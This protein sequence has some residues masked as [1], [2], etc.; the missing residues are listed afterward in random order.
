MRRVIAC[1]SAVAL[2]LGTVGGAAANAPIKEADHVRDAACSGVSTTAGS[3]EFYGM[4]SDQYGPDGYF[5]VWAGEPYASE[6]LMTRDYDRDISV[7]FD[8][9]TVSMAVPL[10][11]PD[12]GQPAGEAVV[13]GTLTAVDTYSWNDRFKDGNS[14]F[15]DTGTGTAFV[16][17]GTVTLPGTSPVSIGPDNCGGSDTTTSG[18]QTQPHARVASFTSTSGSCSLTNGASATADVFI[19]V[20]DGFVSINA[21]VVS[22]EAQIGTSGGGPM[23][24]VGRASFT[25]D[26]YDLDTGV[27]S[28]AGSADVSLASSGET[29][30]YTLRASN[31]V[32]RVTGSAL[33]AAGTLSTSLGDFDLDPCIVAATQAKEIISPSSGPKPG[34]K[35]PVNDLPAGA[36]VTASGYRGTLATRGAERPSEAD[37]P[38]LTFP[39]PFGGSLTVPAEF[40]VWYTL[41]GTGTPITVDTAGSDYD[42][43][44]GVY[45]GSPG[46]FTSV[47]CVDDVPLQPV[48]RTLQAAVTFDTVAGTTYWI[49]IG[50]LNESDPS[51]VSPNVPYGTL[52]LAVR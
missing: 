11:T 26:E 2:L 49:Q 16:F 48:G 18:F 33:D 14:H 27:I 34:G 21:T 24:A 1:L 7:A 39:D 10:V 17:T 3:V 47:A 52:K 22:G 38:C 32:R 31:S 6:L 5:D 45:T 13:S 36:L 9:G 43:V 40:T 15:R 29:I 37:Y 41:A 42:T 51:F 8:S 4:V 20:L 25:L 19:D 50:G 46:S 23:D 12:D 44:V 30:D 35:R 28:G